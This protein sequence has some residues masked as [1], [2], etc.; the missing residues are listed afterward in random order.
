MHGRNDSIIVPGQTANLETAC[1]PDSKH[2]KRPVICKS[3]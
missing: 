2:Q 3:K 1:P